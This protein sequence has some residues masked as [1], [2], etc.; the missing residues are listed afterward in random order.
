VTETRPVDPLIDF[1]QF[2]TEPFLDFE[3]D[4]IDRYNGCTEGVFDCFDSFTV[5][6]DDLPITELLAAVRM[7]AEELGRWREAIYDLITDLGTVGKGLTTAAVRYV[8]MTLTG[9]TA[10]FDTFHRAI[11]KW[12]TGETGPHLRSAEGYR[13]IDGMFWVPAL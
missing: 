6:F 4:A 5:A 11:Q 2:E 7:H 3:L 9:F 1:C 13:Y 10:A 12:L 8:G